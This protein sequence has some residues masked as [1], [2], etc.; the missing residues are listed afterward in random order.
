MAYRVEP[1][2]VTDPAELHIQPV[3]VAEADVKE[4]LGEDD[5]QTIIAGGPCYSA[6]RDDHILCSA[7][8]MFQWY[9]RGISWMHM[10]DGL[11]IKDKVFI[12]RE[13]YAFLQ[14][15]QEDPKYQRIETTV[16][17][18]FG[19]GHHWARKL[20]FVPEG[21]MRRYDHLGNDHVLYARVKLWAIL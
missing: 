14:R 3:Q 17:A 7:G 16:I 5:W 15:T 8:V 1:F 9:G 21:M 11:T 2:R 19:P 4:R 20:G 10:G 6:W 12:H 18:D 13:V